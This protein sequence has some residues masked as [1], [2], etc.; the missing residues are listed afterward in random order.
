MDYQK[1]TSLL[2]D[3][4]FQ[5]K[6]QGANTPEATVALFKENGATVTNADLKELYNQMNTYNTNKSGGELSDQ[7][8]Q[9]V[10]GGYSGLQSW[11]T[12][13]PSSD[14]SR[15]AQMFKRHINQ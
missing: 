4:S 13:T 1:I 10:S 11:L 6:L 14:I 9:G 2:S 8:L 12:Q 15:I 7:Q 5:S 3:S